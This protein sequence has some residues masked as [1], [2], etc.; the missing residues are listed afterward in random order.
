MVIDRSGWET[1]A[2]HLPDSK[3]EHACK[4]H[5]AEI[6]QQQITGPSLDRKERHDRRN[7]RNPQKRQ[8]Q[9]SQVG[10]SNPEEKR[11][12]S[13][14]EQKAQKVNCERR[15]ETRG[16]PDQP[17]RN[18]DGYVKDGPGRRE[19]PVRWPP[20]RFRKAFIPCTRAKKRSGQGGQEAHPNKSHKAKNRGTDHIP[21]SCLTMSSKDTS[22][23]TGAR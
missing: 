23:K 9:E 18:R 13:C 8:I 12:P 19:N 21:A 17:T 16:S 4:A 10:P 20:P 6:G 11:G 3:I 5:P 2:V 7:N 22:L 15:T 14:I 1:C